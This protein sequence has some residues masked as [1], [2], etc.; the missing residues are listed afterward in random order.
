[1]SIKQASNIINYFENSD[2]IAVKVISKDLFLEPVYF[3]RGSY[4]LKESEKQKLNALAKF[5][6]SQGQYNLKATGFTDSTGALYINQ[7]ISR[8]RAESVMNYLVQ[9][10]N[11][12][13]ERFF[14]NWESST[15]KEIEIENGRKNQRRVDLELILN[16]AKD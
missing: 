4:D 1:M 12:S 7:F 9:N 5:L 6:L 10:E 15:D 14:I 13:P 2:K 11:I 8:K 16:N 3:K